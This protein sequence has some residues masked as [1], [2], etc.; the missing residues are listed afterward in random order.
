MAIDDSVS[1]AWAR[2]RVRGVEEPERARRG[3]P[4][5]EKRGGG[6]R[7]KKKEEEEVERRDDSGRRRE[8]KNQIHAVGTTAKEGYFDSHG[9]FGG[10][11]VRVLGAGISPAISS[12]SS[13]TGKK[14]KKLFE[15]FP[16]F[17]DDVFFF[18]A[19]AANIETSNGG[20]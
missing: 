7:K 5:M 6:T 13:S 3:G 17:F 2:D 18:F 16:M 4:G 12:L 1:K 11:R 8:K 19:D 14:R 9:S 10:A 15:F 20:L